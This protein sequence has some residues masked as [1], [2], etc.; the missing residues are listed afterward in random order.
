MHVLLGF[1]DMGVKI[2]VRALCEFYNIIYINRMV[3]EAI[4]LFSTIIYPIHHT[5]ITLNKQNLQKRI[6]S[7]YRTWIVY[8]YDSGLKSRLFDFKIFNVLRLKWLKIFFYYAM[9]MLLIRKYYEYRTKML[10]FLH[11]FA[12]PVGSLTSKEC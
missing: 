10:Y 9:Q 6:L 12:Y 1:V 7:K 5:N 4:I 3:T 8:Y 11:S 2:N